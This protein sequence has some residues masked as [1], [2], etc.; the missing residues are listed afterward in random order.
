MRLKR[1]VYPGLFALSFL[2]AFAIRPVLGLDRD[3]LKAA[4]EY[5]AERD[6]RSFLVLQEDRIIFEDYSN[7]AALDRGFSIFSGTKGFWC[8]LAAA[9]VQDGILDFDERVAQTIPNWASDPRKSRVSI[10]DLLKFTAGIEPVFRLHGTT[11]EDRN[12]YSLKL[13]AVTE[14][15]ESFVYG[16]SQLQV[17]CE[18]LRR[19]LAPRG[20]T[21]QEYMQK[22]LLRPLG[23]GAVEYRE[24]SKGNP[25]LASGFRLSA[26][27]WAQLG[28]LIL[29]DGKWGYRCVVR[30]NLLAEC[31]RGSRIN[32]MFGMGFWLNR[33][34]SEAE[35]REVDVED[36]LDLP[37]RSQN[38]KATCL[39]LD[40]PN[41]LI[42]SIGSGYQRMFIVP[43]L[44]LIIVRQGRSERFSD[45]RFLRIIFGKTAERRLASGR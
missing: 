22:R 42:A 14:P 29:H 15:G 16:P 39:S 21:P 17:F 40:A 34:G 20:L 35:A 27:Q 6:G 5:S 12:A 33:K 23:I 9:A 18:V 24:D 32:P 8:V 13:P 37:W 1:T 44:K 25:L 31:F 45:A 3:S 4:A 11:I 30:S 41:D 36:M 2:I 10:R 19:K 28:K 26:R 7:G 38:W 43:S